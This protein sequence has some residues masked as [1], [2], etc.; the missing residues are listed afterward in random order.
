M[1]KR[2]IAGVAVL[3]IAVAVI[4]TGFRSPL[5]SS[6]RRAWKDNALA[7]ISTRTGT[8]GWLNGELAKLQ[9]IDPENPSDSAGWMSEH[10]IV[11][12][13][14][15]W[16]AYANV[17][18]KQNRRIH[19]LFL[20]FGSDGRWYYS[21][22]HFCKDLIVLQMAGQPEN[23]SAF[24]TDYYLKPFDGLSDECLRQTWPTARVE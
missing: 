14:G 20:A 3:L 8:P 10:L 18:R 17:C 23:L 1:K 13:N 22:F 24:S 6:A 9:S 7:E 21:T 2:V 4:L 5:Q 19:D 11:M 16:L 15:E 12:R